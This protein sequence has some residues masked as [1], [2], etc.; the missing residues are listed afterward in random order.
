M[1]EARPAPVS[2]LYF[3]MPNT[4]RLLRRQITYES[5]K[6]EEVNI[7]HRLSYYDQQAKLFAYA[8]RHP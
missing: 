7:L 3:K 8:I 6:N 5:A 1:E 4:R 2:H